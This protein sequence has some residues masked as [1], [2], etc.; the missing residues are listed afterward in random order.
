MM[1]VVSYLSQCS[2]GALLS[3]NFDAG[4]DQSQPQITLSQLLAL[5]SFSCIITCDGGYK[6]QEGS[7]GYIHLFE[8][9]V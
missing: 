7:I 9:V 5:S 4:I 3:E 6:G 8:V 2:Y 1:D